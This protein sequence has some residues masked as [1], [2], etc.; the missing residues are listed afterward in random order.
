M[1]DPNL[2]PGWPDPNDEREDICLGDECDGCE[3]C[4]PFYPL[5]EEGKVVLVCL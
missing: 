3:E 1:A 2:P 4:N 5:E